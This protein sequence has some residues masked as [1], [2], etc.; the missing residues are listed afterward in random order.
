[1]WLSA[2][3]INSEQRT[4]TSL[5]RLRRRFAFY[6]ISA[7]F[8]KGI[9]SLREIK[10]VPRKWKS[11]KLNELSWIN[12]GV[13]ALNALTP[14]AWRTFLRNNASKSAVHAYTRTSQGSL[15]LCDGRISLICQNQIFLRKKL[16]H[17]VDQMVHYAS[18]FTFL[19][20]RNSGPAWGKN[21]QYCAR[22]R[23][24]EVTKT[25]CFIAGMGLDS[26]A[27]WSCPNQEP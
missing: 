26:I 25:G 1:M 5:K 15:A 18:R 6:G 20:R 24:Q 7:Q 21:R 22:R 4:T 13:A 9:A 17:R 10:T 11:S 27:L 19:G 3:F 12:T 23:V 2:F 14:L 16:Q 8:F